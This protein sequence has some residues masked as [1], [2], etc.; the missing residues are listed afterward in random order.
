M[1]APWLKFYPS[2]WRADPALRMC[3]IGAR[4]LWMEM[5]CVMHEATPRGSLVVNGR[6]LAPRQIAALAGTGVD[7]VTAYLAELEDAGVFS[8]AD[9]GTIFSRRMQRDVEKEAADKA[10]GSKGGNPRLKQDKQGVNP[11]VKTEDKGEDKA[12]KPEARDQKDLP[13][14]K[15]S[16]TNVRSVGKPTRPAP[17]ADFDEFWKAYPHRGE[18]SDPKKPAKEKF[19]R[20]VKRGA[21]PAAI[22]SGAKR[23]AEI[24]RRA[25]RAGTE[26]CA[27][28]VTWLNQERWNDY[29]VAAMTDRPEQIF[30]KRD[31]EEWFARVKAGHKPGLCKFYPEQQADGWYFAAQVHH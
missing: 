18:A 2:D 1:S 22:I 14:S 26:K 19:E 7:E 20:A 23:F 21:D 24:E 16:T 30:V 27:Q 9:D 6:A 28:A 29:A 8:R 10:N 12:Q 15:S 17:Y 13:E 11:P 4:G 31:T 25:G 5:L 3:S